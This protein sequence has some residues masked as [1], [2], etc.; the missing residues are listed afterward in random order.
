MISRTFSVRE[1]LHATG[2]PLVPR[3]DDV[4]TALAERGAAVLRADPGSG[5]STLVPLALMDSPR[6]PGR[7]VMLEPRRVAA[8]A[9]ASR[10]ADLIGEE[11]GGRVG[12]AVRLQRRVGP[13]TRVEVVTEGLLTRRLIADPALD[14]VSVVIFDEFHE[15]SIHADLALALILDLRRLRP[16][17]AVLVMS[18]TMDAAETAAFLASADED[19]SASPGGDASVPVIEVPLKPFPV[20]LAY[21]PLPG[22]DRLGREAAAAAARVV[23]ETEAGDVLV[24]LPGRREIEDC[25]TELRRLLPAV[26]VRA[27]YGAMP[28]EAQ[29]EVI[30]KAPRNGGT[31]SVRRVI[32]ATNIAETSLTVAGVRAVVDSGWV[33]VQ[34]RHPGSG[35]DRLSLE[36]CSGRSAD[37]RSGR[38]GRL[39]P[40]F[41]VRLWDERDRP[42]P[43]TEPEIL[44]EDLAPLVLDC[45]LWG[46]RS[47]GDLRW[48]D[49]PEADAWDAAREGLIALGALD[50]Q[51]APT[52]RG[53]RMASLGVHPRLAALVLAGAEAGKTELACAAAAVLADR[54]LSLIRADADL[55]RRL[56][57][58]R[59]AAD[60]APIGE[61]P[62]ADAASTAAWRARTRDTAADL[63]ARLGQQPRAR[64]LWSAADEPTIGS[65]LAAA[66]PD[67]IGK[68]QASGTFRFPSGRE[69]RVHGPLADAEWLVAPE[70]DAGERSGTIHLASRLDRTD[71][72]RALSIA[73][74][75]SVIP[76]IE[77]YWTG[78][79]P[80]ARAVRRAGRLEVAESR[81]G[82]DAPG[83]EAAV[84]ASFAAFDFSALPWDPASRGFLDR[85]R[86]RAAALN[87][88]DARARLSPQTLASSLD[89]WLGPFLR[90]ES[91]R[92][93]VDAATL[94]EALRAYLG[95]ETASE[96]DRLVP[97]RL[98]TPAG[99]RRRVDYGGAVP[100]LE[101]RIQEC[102]G[103]AESPR[104]LGT[105]VLLKLL[106][107]AERPL[108][109]TDDLASFWKNTYPEIRRELRGRYP[110]HYWPENPLE[111][112]ATSR[113]RPK[114][115]PRA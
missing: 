73:Y 28:L 69:A 43:R 61:T 4:V 76:G 64:T 40:G 78:L 49:P 50:E 5:K 8:L 18:A 72:E 30:G 90:I 101:L 36:R 46:V 84:R 85:A 19:A 9:V 88:A 83:V 82:L 111:A 7:I 67:R 108:Q 38:A 22:R 95:W 105:R 54:D 56:A 39:G 44:R 109:T 93:A 80:R 81:I 6:F 17:L 104:I 3:L 96:I 59:G 47:R 110:R 106:S 20:R 70:A 112:E 34:R 107:P 60:S 33:R 63:A 32:A 86:W 16:D 24:F 23:A 15:R 2:L 87:D 12:Y 58:L 79:I 98:P 51:G 66:F 113:P 10:M 71:A 52:G 68:L 26:E 14:G 74:P 92:D 29:N 21:R 91:G 37:Q 27:L 57:V 94:L 11:P 53:R 100:V 48:L 102:F 65:L 45:A 35:L 13:E 55:S 25:R 75:A 89:Q 62:S 99:T 42:P 41:C 31:A 114:P 97:E 1:A 103:L 115:N 77:I